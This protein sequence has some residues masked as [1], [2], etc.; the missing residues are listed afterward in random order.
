MNKNIKYLTETLFDDI[1]DD[2]DISDDIFAENL[3]VNINVLNTILHKLEN[4]YGL[5]DL[6]FKLKSYKSGYELYSDSEDNNIIIQSIDLYL[7][8]NNKSI[9]I[10][11]NLHDLFKLFNKHNI[12][13][14]IKYCTISAYNNTFFNNYFNKFNL[15][16]YDNISYDI[17]SLNKCVIKNF[18]YFPDNVK[19]LK[20]NSCDIY[21][22]YNFPVNVKNILFSETPLPKNFKGFI[23]NLD[24]LSVHIQPL[25]VLSY[26]LYDKQNIVKYKNI[27]SKYIGN[28]TNIPYNLKINS[29][30]IILNEYPDILKRLLKDYIKEKVKKLYKNNYKS[31]YKQLIFSNN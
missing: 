5:D 8:D 23:I 16:L 4:C 10:L 30:D 20:F 28:L 26:P 6:I 25:R 1:Y 21:N 12:K 2:H 17:L 24:K 11:N 3:Y 27:I 31:L 22:C 9:Y 7:N 14:N 29:S 13:M 15:K 18:N 19:T